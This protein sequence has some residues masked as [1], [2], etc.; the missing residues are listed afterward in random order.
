MSVVKDIRGREGSRQRLKYRR[1]TR[2]GYSERTTN[3]RTAKQETSK[4]NDEFF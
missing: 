2:G 1:P 3:R 4:R